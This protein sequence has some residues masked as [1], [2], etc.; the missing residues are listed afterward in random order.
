[1]V[2]KL[3]G[4]LKDYVEVESDAEVASTKRR[5]IDHLEDDPQQ[6]LDELEALLERRPT[7]RA[8][9]TPRAERLR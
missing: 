5:L 6:L 7:M 4:L 2:E 1:M 9:Y 8:P 3:V